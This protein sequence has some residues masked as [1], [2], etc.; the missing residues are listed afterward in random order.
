MEVFQLAQ[1]SFLLASPQKEG[2][3]EGRK[4]TSQLIHV[5][6]CG[7]GS[8]TIYLKK[9]KTGIIRKSSCSGE[10]HSLVLAYTIFFS[11]D[12]Q[13]CRVQ[14]TYFLNTVIIK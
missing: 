13:V 9:L 4:E 6:P 11:H 5:D 3:K 2:R 8:K 10:A 14:Q 1:L 12:Y 7:L